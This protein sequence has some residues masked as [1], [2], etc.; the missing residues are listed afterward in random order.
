MP[1][2]KRRYSRS[3][4]RRS[5][6]TLSNYSIATRT[7]ARAQS[8]QIYALKRKIRRIEYRTRPETQVYNIPPAIWTPGIQ[9]DQGYSFVSIN[10]VV[11]QDIEGLFA[12]LES[13]TLY[14]NANYVTMTDTVQPIN[15]RVTVFQLTSATNATPALGQLYN[16]LDNGDT[17]TQYNW[18]GGIPSTF[19]R[20]AIFGPLQDGV[21]RSFRII[22]DRKYTLSYQRPQIAAR[23]GLRSLINYGKSEIGGPGAESSTNYGKGSLFIAVIALGTASHTYRVNAKIAYTDA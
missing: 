21:T 14:F 16:D 17:S 11:P 13:A 8:R 22:F 15:Y 23:V 2:N 6:R 18:N 9:S 20:N 19:A 12:R 1:Y 3:S 5:A 7:G 4:R 10:P